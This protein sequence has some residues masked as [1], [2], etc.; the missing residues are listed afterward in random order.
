MIDSGI[1]WYVGIPEAGKT[2]L[3]A[4]HLARAARRNG[5][6]CLVIDSQ[7][8]RNFSRWQY[9]ASVAE[10]GQL[11]WGA[12][13]HCAYTPRDAE[14]VELL[15]TAL[16]EVGQVNVLVDEAAY[17]INAHTWVRSKL[18]R[19]MRAHRHAQ[20]W[21]HLTTQHLSGDVPQA[22][23]SCAPDLFIFRC[24]SK[25][26]LARLQDEYGLESARVSALPQGRYLRVS[27]GFRLTTL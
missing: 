20:V 14:E 22:A 21:L 10:V 15:C 2:T 18:S 1:A 24:T 5:R 25:A 3:A 16:L 11:L 26:V 8:V 9:A 27:Q 12:R 7:G 13:R 19:L 17:W 23:L 6:P 4:H